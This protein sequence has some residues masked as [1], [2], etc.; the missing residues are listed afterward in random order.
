MQ[1]RIIEAA[2]EL[3]V[4][5][6][7]EAVSIRKVAARAGCAPMSIYQVFENK[8]A[9]LRH[10]W[11]D[12]FERVRHRCTREVAHAE[13]A[14]ARLR[15]FAHGFIDY[16]LEHP[17]HYRVIYLNEDAIAEAGHSSFVE[18]SGIVER[19]SLVQDLFRQA[20][21]EGQ[22]ETSDPELVTQALLCV[23]HGIAHS[24]ITIP[25]YPWR[26]RDQVVKATLDAFFGGV[27][28][29]DG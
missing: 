14:P 12:I 5:E 2:R 9:L 11:G 15:A 26:D 20:M 19:F 8:R 23:L 16:W 25:E 10:I 27:G 18:S 7:F 1:R 29:D 6:G 4:E 24:L 3:F 28:I 22:I 21:A 13:G 17:D